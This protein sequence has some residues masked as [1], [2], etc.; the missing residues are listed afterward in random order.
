MTVSVSAHAKSTLSSTTTTKIINGNSMNVYTITSD[1]IPYYGSG[2]SAGFPSDGTY[3]HTPAGVSYT[4]YVP[5]QPVLA[6]TVASPT[7]TALGLSDSLGF[8]L[9]GIPFDPLTS[10]CEGSKSASNTCSFRLEGRLQTDPSNPSSPYAMKRLGF[11]THNGHS[12]SNGA[13]HY[14]SIT[15]GI[16]VGG[17]A[18]ITCDPMKKNN[19]WTGLSSTATVVGYARD[20]YPVVVQSGVYA[21]YSVIS[22]S[23][24]SASRPA[25][26]PS[27]STNAYGNWSQDM[28]TLGN[29]STFTQS[30]LPANKVLADFK[31]TGPST[32]G[33]SS[34]NLGLCNE[35]PNTDASIKT[36][37]NQTASYVYYLTPNFPMIPRCL[38]GVTDGPT[39]TTQGFYHFGSLD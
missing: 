28:S 14:H 35:A 13:Y 29:G 30:D 7:Y 33:T 16:S 24:A 39:G 15:C 5:S 23:D 26:S 25:S 34:S 17:N 37:N 21:N 8:A 31:Y 1:G 11:D 19:P 10:N 36:L 27:D 20:G 2:Y 32:L 38:V 12:Q 6:G 4:W 9:D 22:S 3:L 18:L